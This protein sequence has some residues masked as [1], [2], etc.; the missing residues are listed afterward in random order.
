MMEEFL[1]SKKKNKTVCLS[2]LNK[3]FFHKTSISKKAGAKCKKRSS[4]IK[5]F[6][7]QTNFQKRNK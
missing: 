1:P 3:C 4:S 7:Y 2:E 5:I 6:A